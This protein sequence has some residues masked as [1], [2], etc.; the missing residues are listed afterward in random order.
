M[1][2]LRGVCLNSKF[3]IREREFELCRL[4]LDCRVQLRRRWALRGEL[5]SYTLRSVYTRAQSWAGR[6]GGLILKKKKN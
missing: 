5:R 1:R 4:L 6:W 3:E 2:T